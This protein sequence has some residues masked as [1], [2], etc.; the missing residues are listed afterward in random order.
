VDRSSSSEVRH[1]LTTTPWTPVNALITR[2]SE[3]QIL[4]PPLKALVD[5]P[6]GEP[7]RASFLPRYYNGPCGTL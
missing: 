7:I 3:V 5:A 4:P 2:R 1:R 6:R